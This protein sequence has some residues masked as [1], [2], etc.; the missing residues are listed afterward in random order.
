MKI[1]PSLVLWKVRKDDLVRVYEVALGARKVAL[2]GKAVR[3]N[4][5]A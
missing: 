2:D 3:P 1:P 5:R 4:A